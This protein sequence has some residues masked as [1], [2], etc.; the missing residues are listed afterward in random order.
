MEPGYRVP[1][2]FIQFHLS[3][4]P[5]KFL[6]LHSLCLILVKSSHLAFEFLSQMNL[7]KAHVYWSKHKFVSII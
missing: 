6:L 7:Y 1:L 5:D 2:Y 4:I 3:L